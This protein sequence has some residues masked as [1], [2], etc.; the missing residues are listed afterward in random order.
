MMNKLVTACLCMRVIVR[1]SC[2]REQTTHVLANQVGY[3]FV[4]PENEHHVV[5]LFRRLYFL[6]KFPLLTNSSLTIVPF[7]LRGLRHGWGVAPR[8]NLCLLNSSV[9]FSNE[10]S[11]KKE[12]SWVAQGNSFIC[13]E[14]YRSV[15][16]G[17]VPHLFWALPLSPIPL[18][19]WAALSNLNKK[20]S[21]GAWP[22]SRTPLPR[23]TRVLLAYLLTC[24]C[25]DLH[26]QRVEPTA[27]MEITRS[28]VDAP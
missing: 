21:R 23:N 20:S 19:L 2:A 15:S 1:F 12:G 4:T 22:L 27:S 6:N 5:A 24:T 10:K 16:L 18:P 13:G 26:P 25:C 7:W 14:L 17:M 11:V 9:K 28:R 8:T 3:A